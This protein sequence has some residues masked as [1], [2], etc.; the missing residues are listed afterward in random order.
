M[1]ATALSFTE[2]LCAAHDLNCGIAPDPIGQVSRAD[3]LEYIDAFTVDKPPDHPTSAIHWDLIR[4]FG[5]SEG[6]RLLLLA[7]RRWDAK[8]LRARDIV[9]KWWE[10]HHEPEAWRDEYLAD[11]IGPWRMERDRLRICDDAEKAWLAFG[12]SATDDEVGDWYE[13][14]GAYYLSPDRKLG[15]VTRTPNNIVPF[16]GV[17]IPNTQLPLR[18]AAPNEHAITT[19]QPAWKH[20]CITDANGK[21]LPVLANAVFAIEGETRLVNSLAYDEMMRTTTFTN[22]FIDG[23]ATPRP[24][25]DGDVVKIQ[26]F[27]QRSGISR[28]GK[29]PVHDAVNLVAKERSFHPVRDYLEALRWDGTPRLDKW[30]AT[31]LGTEATPYTGAIGRMFMISMVARIFWPGVKA[32]YM[33]V[34]EGSQGAMKSS[35]CNVLAGIWFSDAMPD[36]GSKDAQQHLRGKWLIEIAEMHAMNRADTAELKQFITRTT[37]Q[38]RP[39]YGRLEVIEPRQCVFIGTTNQDV[40]LRDE[41][42]GRRFWPVRCGRID[43]AKL[44]ADRDQLFAEAVHLYR[45]DTP[46]WP[47]KEFE[48]EYIAPQQS[49]RYEAD[50]WEESIARFIATKTDVTIGEVAANALHMGTAHIGRAEQNRIIAALGRLQW[51]RGKPTATRKPWVRK[52]T[53]T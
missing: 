33:L 6:R 47:D 27:I 30:L 15:P 19:A 39:S 46:W 28:I 24:M 51:E 29:E 7:S 23:V 40:Y 49:S 50:A 37:E 13:K 8:P 14:F 34:L 3:V 9:F 20:E 26:Q 4:T 11:V 22:P 43:L 38:Y 12:G 1:T 45:A 2:Q 41:T 44:T 32:D 36:V 42:G 25:T 31:Y 53:T 18:P 16:P 48:R 17:P 21:I 10:D 5:E 52:L 35:A